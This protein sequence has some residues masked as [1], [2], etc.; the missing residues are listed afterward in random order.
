MGRLVPRAVRAL[1]LVLQAAQVAYAA[2]CSLAD[3]EAAESCSSAGA[4]GHE[5]DS[6]LVNLL[7]HRRS[8]THSVVA[9]ESKGRAGAQPQAQAAPNSDNVPIYHLLMHGVG[10]MGVTM[11]V[12]I[13]TPPQAVRVMLDTGSSTL[14]VPGPQTSGGLPECL[15]TED[16]V[17][18]Y[19]SGS[20]VVGGYATAN[21]STVVFW[22]P[23]TPGCNSPTMVPGMDTESCGFMVGYADKSGMQGPIVNDTVKLGPM[24]AD[25]SFGAIYIIKNGNSNFHGMMMS[26]KV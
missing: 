1:A 7:A 18:S 12:Q 4:A 22:T 25:V 14:G 15:S 11:D 23:D 9:V 13:G 3:G 19:M 5:P 8:L 20:C 6:D 2:D 10:T 17:A 16:P 26:N 24:S 21:S